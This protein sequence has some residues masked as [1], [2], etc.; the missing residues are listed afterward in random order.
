MT[1]IVQQTKKWLKF[2]ALMAAVLPGEAG[3]LGA[4]PFESPATQSSAAKRGAP[5]A[6]MVLL[7]D[8]PVFPGNSDGPATA[9]AN[10]RLALRSRQY[11][12]EIPEGIGQEL[13]GE[14]AGDY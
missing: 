10:P 14:I 9:T 13:P 11:E 7:S 6:G 2:A 4:A 3:F 5:Q 8:E 1:R 12:N